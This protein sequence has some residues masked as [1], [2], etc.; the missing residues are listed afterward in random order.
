[1]NPRFCPLVTSDYEQIRRFLT[2]MSLQELIFFTEQVFNQ[3][4]TAEKVT[5]DINRYCSEY[6]DYGGRI[7]FIQT[8]LEN[9]IISMVHIPFSYYRDPRLMALLRSK[10]YEYYIPIAHELGKEAAALTDDLESAPSST[11]KVTNPRW[12]HVDEARKED[13]PAI[14]ATGDTIRLIVD[15]SGYPE[16]ASVTFDIFDGS[17]DPAMRIETVQGKNE[18]GTASVQWTVSDPNER[19]KDLK[20][21][22][23]GSA[24]SKSSGQAPIDL[25][26]V[27]RVELLDDDGKTIEGVKVEFTVSGKQ[28]VITTNG[29]GV[30]EMPATDPSVDADV[31]I[32]W[33]S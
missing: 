6:I 30:A 5:F 25:A 23:E 17:T 10:E 29:D 27:Y 4:T 2:E 8:L 22:F 33:E 26:A 28:T 3:L 9:A 16:G 31:R 24:R 19:G 15:V 32:L 21:L 12:E 18:N 1:M 7:R 20:L 11:I 14:A 13:S